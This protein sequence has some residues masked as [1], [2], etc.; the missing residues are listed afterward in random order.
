MLHHWSESAGTY[1]RFLCPRKA[2]GIP[3]IMRRAPRTPNPGSIL[4]CNCR[5]SGVGVALAEVVLEG[6]ELVDD[7]E[8]VGVT[9]T[10]KTVGTTVGRVTSDVPE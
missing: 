1:H 10:L 9:V 5:G 3:V 4:V 6:A 8:L 2:L 7:A